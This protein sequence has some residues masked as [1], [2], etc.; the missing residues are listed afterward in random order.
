MPIRIPPI[1]EFP[2]DGR[3]WR[4]DWLGAVER[5]TAE[6]RIDV[7]LSPAKAGEANPRLQSHFEDN[8]STQV[9][10]GVGLLPFLAIGS[11]WRDGRRL[12]QVAG[13][14]KALPNVRIDAKSVRTVDAGTILPDASDK[15]RWL[16]PNFAHQLPRALWSS[17]CFAIEYGGDPYGIVLPVIEAIRFYYA[18]ST[19]LAHIAFNGA[20]QLHLNHVIDDSA[21]GLLRGSDRMVL[22]LRQWLA[23][24]DGWVIG[25]VLADRLAWEGVTRIY[26][27][28]LRNAANRAAVF[29]ECGLP[30]KGVTNWA[31]RG[32]ELPAESG[33]KRW[34]IQELTS[35]SAPF[36]FEEL[37]VVRDNDN[38]RADTE[39]DLP[40]DEK[41]PAWAGPRR[42]AKLAADAQVQSD[43]SPEADIAAIDIPLA[44]ERFGALRGKEIIKTPKEQCR[45]KTS[46]FRRSQTVALLGTGIADG[47][48]NGVAPLRVGWQRDAERRQGLPASFDTLLAVVDALNVQSGVSAT[49]RPSMPRTEF[50]PLTK[51]S[52]HWQWAY[53][54]SASRTRRRVMTIDVE[55]SGIHSSVVE[56]ERRKGERSRLALLM[57][58]ESAA[59]SD[60]RL[61][62]ILGALVAVKGVWAN[63]KPPPPGLTPTLFN[64]SRPSAEAFANDICVALRQ[65]Q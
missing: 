54:D 14:R 11:L 31:T 17:R 52:A 62:L 46:S 40:D 2:K 63:I 39:T 61:E 48:P 59:L 55:C 42:M 37:E 53:L 29:P 50:L 9:R 20:F 7:H 15:R 26:D 18:V 13:H 60:V 22:R 30:F 57:L 65:Q 34:L 10:I 28:L 35:C 33:R 44:G 56:F 6:A 1:R 38:R 19:D 25:R 3:I 12:H 23:D 4:I 49:V 41:R 58:S 8:A 21:S 16:I 64:H 36:P 32:I 27:S 45:Y 5:A 47:E 51:P 43:D 24:D